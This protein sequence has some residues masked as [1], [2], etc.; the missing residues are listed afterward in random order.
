MKVNTPRTHSDN[1][2]IHVLTVHWK[3]PSWI[4]IQLRYLRKNIPNEF[5]S[6]AFLNYIELEHHGRFDYEFYEPISSHAIKLNILANYAVFNSV[7]D[8]DV[9]MFIDGDA[10]PIRDL[11]ALVQSSLEEAPFVAVQRLENNGDLQPH[12]CF[13]FTTVGFW[14]EIRGDWQEGGTWKNSDGV[15]VTDVGGNLLEVF[16]ARGIEWR[17]LLRSNNLDEHP[18]WFGIYGGVIYHHGA[19]FRASVSRSDNKLLRK[20]FS[21]VLPLFLQKK[22]RSARWF[23]RLVRASPATIAADKQARS[24]LDEIRKNDL[25]YQRFE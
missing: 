13:A 12:P 15:T 18:L 19:G 16:A 10:F 5:K 2:N 20:L 6:Y 21:S 4:E 14:K 22:I 3:D 23:K 24:M 17:K 7:S 8:D 1:R 9:I 11:G 25:F